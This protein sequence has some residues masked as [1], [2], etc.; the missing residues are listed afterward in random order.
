MKKIGE[1]FKDRKII[2]IIALIA[3]ALV[4]ILTMLNHGERKR[5][6]IEDKCGKF[7][8][9]VQHT[10]PDEGTCRSRCRS[11]CGSINYEYAKVEF[12]EDNIGC[13]SCACY[14]K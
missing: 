4:I 11:Q 9:L 7:V 14:C 6:D 1:M 3:I 12:T 8:N 5:F 13:N 10:I 2:L